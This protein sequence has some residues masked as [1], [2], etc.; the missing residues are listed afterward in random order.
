M[1]DASRSVSRWAVGVVLAATLLFGAGQSPT[2][3]FAQSSPAATQGYYLAA[4]DGGV[5]TFGHAV[6]HGS[7]GGVH[8]DKPIVGITGPGDGSGYYLAAADG[9][10]FTFGSVSFHGSAAG[11]AKSPIVGIAVT[12]DSGGYWLA[13]ADGSV[14]AFGDAKLYG[15]LVGDHLNKPIVGLAATPDGRG[16]W[17]VAADGGVFAFGDAAFFGSAAG[18]PT[19]GAVVG[20]T[21]PPGGGYLLVTSKGAVIAFAPSGEY[22]DH[23]DL[24]SE[25]LAAPIV[26]VSFS[27]NGAGGYWLS[28]QDGGV[29]TFGDT[30][31][32]G[33]AAGTRLAAPVVAI[34][35]VGQGQP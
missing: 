2:I 34:S 35:S 9:G 29:F 18:H 22:P 27:R 17:L 32:F 1:G 5:F 3:A 24:S 10:V 6:F 13:G 16:Y 12:P 28:A 31:F 23:G 11:E 19:D 4:A 7:L 20:I 33:S 21:A 30:T 15:S 26:G 14:F 8:L 25:H